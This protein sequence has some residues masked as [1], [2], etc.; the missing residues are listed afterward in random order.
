MSEKQHFETKYFDEI[1]TIPEN[2]NYF[3]PVLKDV[4]AIVDVK[5]AKVLD[6]GCGTGLFMS[7]VIQWGCSN[8]SGVDGPTDCA[9]RAIARGYK[10]VRVVDD[11][12]ESSLPFEDSSFDLVVCKDVFEHLLNPL[13]SLKEIYRVVK[14]GGYFLLHVP[15][16]FPL[17]GRLKFLFTNE[18]DTFSYFRGA[19]RWAFPHVR[20]YEHNDSCRVLNEQGFLLV[21]ELSH[22]FSIVPGLSHFKIFQPICRSLAKKYPNQFVEGFTY[23]VKK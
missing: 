11:L 10:E 19:S 1:D 16:H 18:L 17:Y 9:D 13:H 15:N 3:L 23:L 14:P 7:P 20:F 2:D 12:S 22:H 4:A 6:V 5:T 8:L 21:S